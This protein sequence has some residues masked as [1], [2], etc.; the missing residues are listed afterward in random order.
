MRCVHGLHPTTGH[1]LIL[2]FVLLKTHTD[3]QTHTHSVTL[4]HRKT[5]T[6][7]YTVLQHRLKHILKKR[8]TQSKKLLQMSTHSHNLSHTHTHTPWDTHSSPHTA[9]RSP[10]ETFTDKW[11]QQLKPS[12]I[13]SFS[14]LTLIQKT[15]DLRT[16]THASYRL[17]PMHMIHKL[18]SI[19]TWY[20]NYNNNDGSMTNLIDGYKLESLKDGWFTWYPETVTHPAR[21]WIT[22]QEQWD[23]SRTCPWHQQEKSI[24]IGAW[25]RFSC[26]RVRMRLRSRFPLLLSSPSNWTRWK[27]AWWTVVCLNLFSHE[28]EMKM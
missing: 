18:R 7:R 12:S 27:S 4:I 17:R 15:T 9:N 14:H 13:P 19:H 23:N 11:I 10:T 1:I 24:L 16:C 25:F 3:I 20:T 21:K 6:H 22:L 28:I 2:L 8:H 5:H 26:V